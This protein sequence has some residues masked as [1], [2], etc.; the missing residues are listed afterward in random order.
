VPAVDFR[1]LVEPDLPRVARWLRQKHVQEWWK[2]PRAPEKV[3]EKYLPR[4]LGQDPTDM[5]VILLDGA[6][7][8]LIQSYRIADHPEWATM[9][10]ASGLTFASAAGIDYMIGEPELV[11]RGIGSVA[12]AQFTASVFAA[13]PEVDCIVVTPQAA[14]RRSCRVLEKS[15]YEL[16]WTGLLDSDDP[17]DA[18]PAAL[19]VHDRS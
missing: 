9:V 12:I 3:R 16:R 4:I 19:Y 1:P 5:F 2:D 14:N 11:G 18:G 8:G 15:G 13:Y 6:E 10:A 7:I 17:S